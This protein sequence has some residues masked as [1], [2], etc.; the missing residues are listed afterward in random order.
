LTVPNLPSFT[1]VQRNGQ[2]T[3]QRSSSRLLVGFTVGKV[4]RPSGGSEDSH[5]SGTT[6]S[7]EDL[8][9]LV[10]VV[11]HHAGLGGSLGTGVNE[12]TVD[13]FD[14]SES[15]LPQFKLDSNV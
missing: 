7:N 10:V 5:G 4:S 1:L 2:G 12:E 13:I 9:E 14:G 11:G 6:F 3:Q 8:G 15:L